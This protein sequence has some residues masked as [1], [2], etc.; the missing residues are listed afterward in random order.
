VMDAPSM[1]HELRAVLADERDAIRRL[2]SQG[3]VL[4]SKRKEDLIKVIAAAVEPE[5]TPM[6][7]VLSQVRSELKRNLVLLAHARDLVRDAI[8]RTRAQQGGPGARVS[9]QL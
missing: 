5:R 7:Q 1:L 9:I 8:E 4:A 2:D 6:L 3:I